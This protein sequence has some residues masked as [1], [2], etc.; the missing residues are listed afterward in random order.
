M[1]FLNEIIYRQFLELF[2]IIFNEIKM[3]PQQ[4][5]TW[6]DCMDVQAGLTLCWLQRL[7]TFG[8]SKIQVNTW[9]L[10]LVIY[11]T[12]AKSII[13][14][15]NFSNV[16][17]FLLYFIPM[18]SITHFDDYCKWMTGTFI[19]GYTVLPDICFMFFSTCIYC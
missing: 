18:Q 13:E 6:S 5:R 2:I 1:N 16:I 12:R 17:F 10:M 14:D 8:F 19:R 11:I 9:W 4:Y 7:I 3:R 15:N